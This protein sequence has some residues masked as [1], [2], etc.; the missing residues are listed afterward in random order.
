MG[1]YRHRAKGYAIGAKGR[2]DI[3]ATASA[4]M[5]KKDS[6]GLGWGDRI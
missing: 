4:V 6:L 1:E 5:D 3:L 2:K